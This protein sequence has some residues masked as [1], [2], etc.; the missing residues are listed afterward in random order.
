MQAII[1]MTNIQ[2]SYGKGENRVHALKDVS[3]TVEPGEF[4]AKSAF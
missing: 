1:E 4:V 3:L 2:K